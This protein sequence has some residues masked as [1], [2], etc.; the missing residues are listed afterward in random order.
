MEGLPLTAW[1]DFKFT[2]VS[3]KSLDGPALVKSLTLVHFL[4][5]SLT[6]TYSNVAHS[7]HTHT[8]TE[9][10]YVSAH[11]TQDLERNRILNLLNLLGN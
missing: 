6:A 5:P 7:L 3:W 1:Q 4:F 2:D 8:Y 9:Y 11:S 10:M